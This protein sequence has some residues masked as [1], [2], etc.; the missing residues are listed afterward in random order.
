MG[1]IEDVE[2]R[3]RV[4]QKASVVWLSEPG[5]LVQRRSGVEALCRQVSD[6]YRRVLP[7]NIHLELATPSHPVPVVLNPQG[8]E[9]ALLNLVINARQAMGEGG[10]IRLRLKLLDR[11]AVLEVE[12]TGSGIPDYQLTEVFKP[13]FTTKASGVGTGLGLATVQRF[14]TSSNGEV[15]VSSQLGVGTT[16][17]LEF[18]VADQAG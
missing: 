12:D 9:H 4:D 13:F 17:S 5:G 11:T 14:V 6:S 3:T 8:L 10:E 2:R 7:A 18:P 15:K 16:F 1:C